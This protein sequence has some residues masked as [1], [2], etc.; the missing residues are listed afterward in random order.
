MEEDTAEKSN[1]NEEA[2]HL[3]IAMLAY[4]GKPHVGGQGVYVREM[5]KALA[6]LGHTVEVFGGPPYPDLDPK[7][8]LHEFPSLEIYNDYF[9]G[10]MPGIWEIKDMPDFVE[11]CSYLTGNFSEPLSFS[12]RAF[13]AVSYTHLTLPTT[14]YV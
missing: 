11:L 14:P 1:P 13:R 6:E 3:R 9:P 12:L 2:G 10:R 4:R 8:P 7:V 5:S